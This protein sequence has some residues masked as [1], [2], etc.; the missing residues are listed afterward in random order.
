MEKQEFKVA[1]DMALTRDRVKLCLEYIDYLEN[2]IHVN[3]CT[4]TYNLNQKTM[5]RVGGFECKESNSNSFHGEL[6]YHIHDKY[7]YCPFC[8]K[9]IKF[10]EEK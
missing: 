3:K 1:L 6:I 8:G 7:K 9:E 4:F 5:G 2:P 10:K